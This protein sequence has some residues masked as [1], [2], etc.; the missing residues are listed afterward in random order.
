VSSDKPGVMSGPA[1]GG[2]PPPPP[3][4][5]SKSDAAFAEA[6][7]VAFV[8]GS[9][10]LDLGELNDL[11]TRVGFPRRDPSRLAAALAA[12]HRTVWVR[13][14]RKSR[15]AREGQLLGFARATSDRALCATIWDVAVTPAWQRAGLGRGMVERLTACL[16]EVRRRRRRRRRRA[17]IPDFQSV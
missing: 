14:A 2:A 15:T 12:T 16:V 5:L 10:G 3:P 1:A 7:G 8:W 4:V 9:E 11:F 6:D 17:L 13:A